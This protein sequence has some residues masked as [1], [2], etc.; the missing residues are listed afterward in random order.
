MGYIKRDG[1]SPDKIRRGSI[2]VVGNSG[3]KKVKE[4]L[5]GGLFGETVLIDGHNRHKNLREAWKGVQ[6][7]AR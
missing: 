4:D 7:S 6:N 5:G 1:W 3:G 2:R